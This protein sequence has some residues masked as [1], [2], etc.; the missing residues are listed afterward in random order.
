MYS[1]VLVDVDK[2]KAAF[3]PRAAYFKLTDGVQ[4]TVQLSNEKAIS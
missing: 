2:F 1:N 3:E 4:A